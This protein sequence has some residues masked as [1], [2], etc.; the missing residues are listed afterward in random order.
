MYQFLVCISLTILIFAGSALQVFALPTEKK[1]GTDL[2]RQVESNKIQYGLIEK[3]LK[4]ETPVKIPEKFEK[5]LSFSIK[6]LSSLCKSG[7]MDDEGMKTL[8][9][10]RMRGIF[11]YRYSEMKWCRASE[12]KPESMDKAMLSLMKS[13]VEHNLWDTAVMCYDELTPE[14]MKKTDL[15][16]SIISA[17]VRNG[18]KGKIVELFS[19]ILDRD[20]LNVSMHYGLF[21]LNR[22]LSDVVMIKDSETFHYVSDAFICKERSRLLQAA[23]WRCFDKYMAESVQGTPLKMYFNAPLKS[24]CLQV[25]EALMQEGVLNDDCLPI[26][27]CLLTQDTSRIPDCK[28]K[29]IGCNCHGLPQHVEMLPQELFL[30]E[31]E[32]SDELLSEAIL[33]GF[34]GESITRNKGKSRSVNQH[35]C[36]NA[37]EAYTAALVWS[38]SHK[39]EISQEVLAGCV[40]LLESD[41]HTGFK[42]MVLKALMPALARSGA[43][44]DR[45]VTW[46]TKTVS[47]GKYKML[48]AYAAM[49]LIIIYGDN[50]LKLK[51]VA[52]SPKVDEGFR[53]FGPVFADSVRDFRSAPWKKI[54]TLLLQNIRK[55]AKVPAASE[56][57]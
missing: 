46:L 28:V 10:L 12:Q 44:S 27:V 17:Y 31:S 21:L 29:T 8:A 38:L 14:P 4:K 45:L 40:K 47:I 20:P 42:C 25:E 37:P 33:N 41:L 7:A 50:Y 52:F 48:E 24:N 15:L 55:A 13:C 34:T 35:K 11:A 9:L 19:T 5:E 49:N 32:V 16:S 6:G 18:E 39:E 36:K 1:A 57:N 22:S 51:D 23:W 54:G 43:T 30:L 3:T 26:G 56:T 53:M 2:E